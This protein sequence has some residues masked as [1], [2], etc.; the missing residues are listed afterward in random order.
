MEGVLAQLLLQ[1]PPRPSRPSTGEGVSTQALSWAWKTVPACAPPG[2][3]GSGRQ[4]MPSPVFVFLVHRGHENLPKKSKH[5]C[6]LAG[7]AMLIGGQGMTACRLCQGTSPCQ[8]PLTLKQYHR[9]RNR[10]PVGKAFVQVFQGDW[11][12]IWSTC[13]AHIHT[14]VQ[15]HTYTPAPLCAHTHSCMGTS[16]QEGPRPSSPPLGAP[17]PCPVTHSGP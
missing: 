4:A 16:R 11:D 7:H 8:E 1:M 17:T 5:E 10:G 2:V 15:T 12:K 6:E 14:C 13:I 9:W 3:Y